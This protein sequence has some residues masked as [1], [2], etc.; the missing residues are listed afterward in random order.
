[1]KL[2]IIVPLKNEHDSLDKLYLELT[3][4]ISALNLE[5]KLIFIDDGS[6]DHSWEKIVTISSLDERVKGIKFSRNFG[7]EAAILAGL[8]E[9]EDGPVIIID[10]DLQ[11]PPSL[12]PKMYSEWLENKYDVVQAIKKDPGN[13]P[14]FRILGVN[15]FYYILSKYSGFD[16]KGHT[17]FKLLDRKVV[18][19]ILSLKEKR[20]FFRGL[21]SWYGYKTKSL[22]FSVADRVAGGTQWKFTNLISFAIDVLSSFTNF[23]LR[24]LTLFCISLVVISIVFIIFVI[25]NIFIGY[26]VQPIHLLILSILIT[27]SLLSIGISIIGEYVARIYDEIKERPDYVITETI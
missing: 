11:H 21:V 19:S 27:G 12:I 24:L 20:R 6:N 8:R 22:E 15:I 4:N 1:M 5:T 13:R 17:D 16:F 14:I 25:W 23:P 10:A 7:K 26:D 9:S 2:N 3:R 18:I